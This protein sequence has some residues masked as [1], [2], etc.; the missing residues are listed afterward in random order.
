MSA[1]M[2]RSDSSSDVEIKKLEDTTGHLVS[3]KIPVYNP[4]NIGCLVINITLLQIPT[5]SVTK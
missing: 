5:I 3:Q 2:A 4:T 1:S